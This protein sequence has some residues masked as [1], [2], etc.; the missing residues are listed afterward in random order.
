MKRLL[1]V[2]TASLVVSTAF[3]RPSGPSGIGPAP[4][5]SY[6]TCEPTISTVAGNGS[7]GFYGDG[8]SATM[9]SLNEPGGVTVDVAGNLY[10]A[11]TKNNRVRIVDP[12][13]IIT[14]VAGNGSDVFSGDGGPA[15]ESSLGFAR[16]SGIRL[17]AGIAV[18]A[19]GNIYIPERDNNRIRK[20]ASCSTVVPILKNPQK[21]IYSK[22]P[23]F[24]FPWFK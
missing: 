12:S 7:R 19:T 20:V 3:A 17:V 8:G 13:G 11:D 21:A 5:R 16:N 22:I 6:P 14:T 18:D 2:I 9:A 4:R 10:I 15:T 23:W 24:R 1:I